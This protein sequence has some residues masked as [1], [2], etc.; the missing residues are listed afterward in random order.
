MPAW[1]LYRNNRA[2]MGTVQTSRGCPF[3]CE[4]CDVIQYLG[5]KQRHKP[6]PQVLA[7]LDKLYRHGYRYVFL[8][9]DNFTIARSR[10]KELLLALKDWNGRQSAGQVSFGTQVSIDAAKDDELLKMCAEAG[11]NNVFIG[12]ETPNEDSLRESKKRQNLGINLVDQI[13]RFFNHGINVVGGMIVG[14]DSD[15]ADIFETQ[16]QFAM[17]SSI[18]ILSVGALVAPEATPLYQRMML[19]GRLDLR[20]SE[21]AAMPWSTNIF[22]LQMTQEELMRGIRWLCNSL[23]RPAAI[24]ERMVTFI[25]KLENY[26]TAA[27]QNKTAAAAPLR[28]IDLDVTGLILNLLSSGPEAE[29]MYANVCKAAAQ[30][31]HAERFVI[32]TLMQYS[33]IRYMYKRGNFWDTNNTVGFATPKG[34]H[35]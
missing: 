14:F 6:I 27:Y 5:R 21:V 33:Q 25:E 7:E 24:G 35:A 10:A 12:I 3:E 28:P 19:D 17:T 8:A 4:F 20:G 23:Y 22:P 18:P 13:R 31:P 30:K 2:L 1:E 9:D 15:R 26:P 29:K 32:N 11:L 34:G 16:Y